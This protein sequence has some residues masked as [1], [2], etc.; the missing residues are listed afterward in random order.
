MTAPST[1]TNSTILQ[2]QSWMALFSAVFQQHSDAVALSRVRDG[3]L[4][5]V[6]EAWLALT[7]YSRVETIGKTTVELGIWGTPDVRH[8]AMASIAAGESAQQMEF[9]LHAKG[10]ARRAVRVDGTRL[11]LNGEP[12][13]LGYLRDIT[14]RRDSAQVLQE[15]LDFIQQLTSRAPVM[16][17]QFRRRSDGSG[18][19]PYATQYTHH[20]FGVAPEALMADGAKAFDAVHI[21][22]RQGMLDSINVSVHELTPWRYEFRVIHVT[23]AVLW[24]FGDAVPQRQA[25]GS[26]LWHGTFTDVT[27]RKREHDELL[28][29]RELMAQKAQALRI[30]LDNMSQGIVTLDADSNIT[31]FNRNFL[32]FLDF[33]PS[34]L[35][36]DQVSGRDLARYQIARGDFGA[37]MER[38]E[39][40]AR[41][42]VA[43]D[44]VRETPDTYMRKS[45]SGRTLE[46]KTRELPGGGVVRTY[47]DVTHFVEAQAALH[48]SEVR[49][50]S[51]TALSSDWYWEQDEN[52]MFVRVDGSAFD[53]NEVSTAAYLGRTRW[54]GGDHGVSPDLWAAHKRMLRDH[55]TF[56]NFEMQRPGTSGAVAWTSISGMPI[57]D[58]LGAFRGY[59]GI[60]RD[61][62]EN[63]R[64][65]DENQRL[66]FYDTLTGLPNRRLL[67]DRL[68]KAM[69]TSARNHLQ[70]ALLF[71]DLDNFKDLNDTMGH[72]VGDKLLEHVARRL[73]ASVRQGDTVA[74]FGGDEFVVMLENLNPEATSATAQVQVVGE[75]ILADL[76]QPFQ[77]FGKGHF[78][79]PSIGIALFSGH[80]QSTDELLKR[81][82]LAMYQAKAAGR[83]TLRFFD[84]ALQAAVAERVALEIDLRHGLEHGELVLYYQP[85]VDRTGRVTGLEA[86]VRWLHPKRGMV[87]PSVFIPMAEETGLIL[88]LGK[89]V[90]HTACSQLL[91]WGKAAHTQGLSIAVNVS[92]REFRQPEF[93]SQIIETLHRTGANPS[94]LKLELTESLLLSD[95]QDAIRKMEQLKAIGVRFSLD[96]FGTGYSSLSY[97]KRLPLDQLKIDQ[98]FVRDVLTDPNDAAIARTVVA[99]AQSL[100]LAVVAEGVETAGQRDF[101]LANGCQAF[102]GYLFGRPV[103]VQELELEGL[104]AGFA[105]S[106]FVI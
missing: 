32:E 52:F 31:L 22:D 84:P 24:M 60:G 104:A 90:L 72:D 91:A 55:Q 34:L 48:E 19:F 82:D 64:N 98:S 20:V 86:L 12:H 23:D 7:G 8:Q 3:L 26:V 50:R 36:A 105:D 78:S 35:H 5:E 30:A 11:V 21:D 79:T 46:I 67:L 38:V 94:R 45:H 51:L 13:M 43:M 75:K 40:H 28:K 4:L 9:T 16:L 54:D 106:Q 59:R 62:T 95:V 68:S 15:K 80:Q 57:F 1:P 17:F 73:V 89:W 97:L 77:L 76:N 103:P 88:P 101:L 74:R 81:A 69:A 18:H 42:Y 102:Q 47:A 49:F 27:E 70:A 2:S 44:G 87:M 53:S 58:G 100:G 25:D 61:I 71:I 14:G 29:T 92:A 85:I 33:P 6:N 63:R 83:N 56:R 99:L 41:G 93:A 37:G 65:D 10:G 39:S 66:A 96:D